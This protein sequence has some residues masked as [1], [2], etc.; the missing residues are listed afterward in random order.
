ESPL[1]KEKPIEKEEHVTDLESTR[2]R[3]DFSRW[4]DGRPNEMDFTC[5]ALLPLSQ[6]PGAFSGRF[7]A[8][9]L[10]GEA[11]QSYD[12]EEHRDRS[13]SGLC[14]HCDEPWSHDYHCKKGRLLMIE[15]IEE[16]E[17]E[18]LKPEEEDTKKDL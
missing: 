12:W 10:E 9:H 1:R 11:I 7:V 14:W 5:K 15:P 6:D 3:V 16:S 4:E 17:N 2:M 13:V 18:D 8:I